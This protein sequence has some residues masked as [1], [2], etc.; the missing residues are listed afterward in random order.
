ME[1]LQLVFQSSSVRSFIDSENSLVYRETNCTYIGGAAAAVGAAGHSRAPHGSDGTQGNYVLGE[2]GE[3]SLLWQSCPTAEALTAKSRPVRPVWWQ[4]QPGPPLPH[5]GQES[6]NE[7]KQ[8]DSAAQRHPSYADRMEKSQL[9][10]VFLQTMNKM[11]KYSLEL[12]LQSSLFLYP[13]VNNPPCHSHM[14]NIP[15][16]K[17]LNTVFWSCTRW[18][19][20]SSLA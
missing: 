4:L 15:I 2:A 1:K 18:K 8:M 19:D 5:W 17:I 7:R 14:V 12:G 10:L 16:K 11:H 13:G 3:V 9:L 6:R 20:A